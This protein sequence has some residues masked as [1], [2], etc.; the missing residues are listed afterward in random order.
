[1]DDERV[2]TT[3]QQEKRTKE[4]KK[5][6]KN[7]DRKCRSH[8]DMT[9]IHTT[10][11]LFYSVCGW[12]VGWLALL[13][14]LYIAPRELSCYRVFGW[15]GAELSGGTGGSEWDFRDWT[16]VLAGGGGGTEQRRRHKGGRQALDFLSLSLSPDKSSKRERKR[17]I[18]KESH[19]RLHDDYSSN[20][21]IS[22]NVIILFMPV[23]ARN[24]GFSFLSFFLSFGT[25]GH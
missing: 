9:G 22:L 20:I 17:N 11:T 10:R 7:P 2:G 3:Q 16:F 12:L 25:L 19:F 18:R 13:L 4:R 8:S 14:L 1:M 6:K 5:E 21:I 23:R 15:F 24:Y